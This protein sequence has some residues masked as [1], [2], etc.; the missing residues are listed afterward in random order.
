MRRQKGFTLIELLVVI[1]II[2]ILAAILFPVFA[3]AREKA[4]TS[5][6]TSN[7]KQ[8]GL[9][10]VQYVQDY[11]EQYPQ[12]FAGNAGL[13]DMWIGT[14]QPYVKN[15][16]IFACPS[17]SVALPNDGW[18][19]VKDSYGYNYNIGWGGG[20]IAMAAVT[21]PAT[22]VLVGETGTSDANMT[23]AVTGV[24]PFGLSQ[25]Y[26]NGGYQAYPIA[27][28]NGVSNVLF[29]DGHAKTMTLTAFFTPNVLTNY[30]NPAVGGP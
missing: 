3:K 25:T 29:A 5:S 26:A 15:T 10:F 14:V 8:I 13:Q 20:H 19:P 2:A 22:T 30:M 12:N 28:H 1:A 24:N 11:D 23:V 17:D 7:C 9:A 21:A 18:C 6:C 16:Q 27:R 4:R